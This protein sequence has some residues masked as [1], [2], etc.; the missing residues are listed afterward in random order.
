M[1][2]MF[3]GKIEKR[4]QSVAVLE[5]EIDGPVVFWRVFLGKGRHHGFGRCAIFSKPDFAQILMSIGLHG[6]R[7]FVENV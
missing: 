7:Q 3:G 4:Q 1:R 5:Q 2:P 6:L